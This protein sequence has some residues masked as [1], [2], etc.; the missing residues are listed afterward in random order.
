[1]AV[2]SPL[3]VLFIFIVSAVFCGPQAYAMTCLAPP[4]PFVPSDPAQAREFADII[5]AT[6]I[7]TFC[8]IRFKA[9]FPTPDSAHGYTQYLGGLLLRQLVCGSPRIHIFELPEG[10][11][12]LH[13]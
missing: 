1:M 2:V 7:Q 13:R 4:R 6:V 12:N 3:G 10:F 5:K 8:A 9:V 11:R